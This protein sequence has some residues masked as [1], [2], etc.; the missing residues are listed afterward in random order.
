[1]YTIRDL[2]LIIHS[3]TLIFK[4]FELSSLVWVIIWPILSSKCLYLIWKHRFV[5]NKLIISPFV[6]EL[7]RWVMF[8]FCESRRQR[9]LTLAENTSHKAVNLLFNWDELFRGKSQR[10]LERSASSRDK[11]HHQRHPIRKW[12]EVIHKIRDL[13]KDDE[14]RINN[15]VLIKKFDLTL[16]HWWEV[17]AKGPYAPFQREFVIAG[18]IA[19]V[20]TRTH[21]FAERLS[22]G[23]K[24]VGGRHSVKSRPV[25]WHRSLSI[26]TGCFE[27]FVYS[28]SP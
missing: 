17:M 21:T 11:W 3:L 18:L 12:S 14:V 4:L 9:Q 6:Y 23:T 8:C 26:I 22:N 13:G 16:W 24:C 2:I 25:Q 5:L 15:V 27:I 19:V 7:L 1:M 28:R 10:T 20:K